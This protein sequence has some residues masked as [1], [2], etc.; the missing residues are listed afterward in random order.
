MLV[1]PLPFVSGSDAADEAAA[2]AAAAACLSPPGAADVRWRATAIRL[3]DWRTWFEEQ[4]S[5]A[6]KGLDTGLYISLRMDGR[7]RGSGRGS[8]PWAIMAAQLP[9]QEGMFGGFLDGMDGRVW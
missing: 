3:G 8:P 7:V 4:A 6:G 1:V 5:A 2:E 9:K